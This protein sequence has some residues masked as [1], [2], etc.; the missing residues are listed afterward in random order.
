MSLRE[1]EKFGNESR[2]PKMVSVPSGQDAALHKCHWKTHPEKTVLREVWATK[3][4]LNHIIS[5]KAGRI[6]LT[7]T[8]WLKSPGF[9]LG[10]R[11]LLF[12]SDIHRSWR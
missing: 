7:G 5:L 9:L 8:W 1:G 3:N 6:Q 11:L 2:N 4:P 10:A 12:T